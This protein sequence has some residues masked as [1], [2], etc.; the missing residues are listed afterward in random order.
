[1]E[2][3]NLGAYPVFAQFLS[4]TN[5]DSKRVAGAEQADILARANDNRLADDEI[6]GLIVHEWFTFLSDTEINRLIMGQGRTQGQLD[7][8]RVPGADDGHVRQA[9][10]E[11]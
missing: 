3:G 8:H 4:R 7:L 2:A 11:G 10:Q 1:M 6:H 9:S 5:R